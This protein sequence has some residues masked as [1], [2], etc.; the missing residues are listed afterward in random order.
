MAASLNYENF[1]EMAEIL[2]PEP[3]IIHG[4][5]QTSEAKT[6]Q[7]NNTVSYDVLVRPVGYIL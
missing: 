2:R 4:G 3:L 6:M 7:N 1:M 5:V